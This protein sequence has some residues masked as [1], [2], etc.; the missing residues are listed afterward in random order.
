[1]IFLEVYFSNQ[2]EQ[3]M[4]AII[5]NLFPLSFMNDK[6]YRNYKVFEVFYIKIVLFLSLS[7]QCPKFPV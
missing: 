7:L 4:N 6:N 1:M 2:K 5:L 3:M